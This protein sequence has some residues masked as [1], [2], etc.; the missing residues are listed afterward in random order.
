MTLY[1]KHLEVSLSTAFYALRNLQVQIIRLCKYLGDKIE[2]IEISAAKCIETV[3]LHTYMLQE[4]IE[5]YRKHESLHMN[6]KIMLGKIYKR[7]ETGP[8]IQCALQNSTF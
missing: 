4:F 8:C 6:N 7:I 1:L 2:F 3:Q 5:K